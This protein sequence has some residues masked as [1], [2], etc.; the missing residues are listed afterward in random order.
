M[1]TWSGLIVLTLLFNLLWSSCG[2]SSEAN[3][4]IRVIMPEQYQQ[5]T[6]IPFPRETSIVKSILDEQENLYIAGNTNASTLPTKNAFQEELQG[7]HSGFIAKISSEGE[8]LWCTYLGGAGLDL[9]QDLFIDSHHQLVILG[10]S[11][12]SQIALH[13]SEE[14]VETNDD[15][16]FF[17]ALMTLDGTFLHYQRIPLPPLPMM[18]ENMLSAQIYGNEKHCFILSP[19]YLDQLSQ[20][21]ELH[22]APLYA[23]NSMIFAD[24]AGHIIWT[25]DRQDFPHNIKQVL[26]DASR[27]AIYIAG[28]TS[29]ASFPLVRASLGE[30][31][32]DYQ[33]NAFLL[34][35]D[36][37][38]TIKWSTFLWNQA[39]DDSI[40]DSI[41]IDEKGWLYPG[42]SIRTFP[43]GKDSSAGNLSVW[44]PASNLSA[45]WRVV[46]QEGHFK[47]D[48]R[49]DEAVYPFHAWRLMGNFTIAFNQHYTMAFARSLN[50]VEHEDEL[51]K[52]SMI[53]P[54]QAFPFG[55][56]ERQE[57]D[58]TNIIYKMNRKGEI[59]FSTYYGGT[60][61]G[62]FV[63]EDIKLSHHDQLFV[64]GRLHN[65]KP[66]QLSHLDIPSEVFGMENQIA[67]V[68]VFNPE[69]Q[70][71][72]IVFFGMDE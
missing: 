58:E 14:F 60:D 41:Y 12:S 51:R 65:L 4:P 3:N 15:M 44:S 34:K 24:Y 38:G 45:L 68:S 40:A 37:E 67:F 22:L 20:D 5:L 55:A 28:S 64:M 59:V 16:V 19:W 63:V 39:K 52:H 25:K 69:G 56:S 32:S 48:Q 54:Y 23:Q 7:E 6:T 70:K 43:E 8:I 66:S 42:G 11:N 2:V 1:K 13:A 31:T 18:E 72:G 46:D 33:S 62:S 49:W 26:L 57:E 29:S 30:Y 17:R 27:N 36:D 47:E 71:T 10:I 53:R 61:P 50:L 9:M 35:M 21:Q